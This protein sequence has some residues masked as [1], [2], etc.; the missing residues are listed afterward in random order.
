MKRDIKRLASDRYDLLVIGGGITGACVAAD[1]AMRGM[2]VAL[3]EKK[4]FGWAT[5]AAT[6]KLI[7][8]GLR[9]LKN[10]EFSLVRESLRERRIFEIIAPHLVYPLPFL[11][12]TYKAGNTR[13]L[14]Y[15][16]MGLYD[17]LSFDKANLS[18]PDRRIPHATIL[19][20]KDV[21]KHEP[22]VNT[23][24]LTGGA[25]YYDCQMF[26]PERLTLEFLLAATENGAELANY[27]GVT[28]LMRSGQ[29]IEGAFVR[30][31]ETGSEFEIRAKITVNVSGP[32]ADEISD[33]L[34][35]AKKKKIVRSQG[36]HLITRNIV[37]NH[38]VVL[39]TTKGRHFFLIPWRGYT[40]I[41]TTDTRYE[42]DPDDYGVTSNA[43]DEFLNEVNEVYPAGKLNMDDV[44]WTYGGLRPIVEKETEIKEVYSA[45]RKYEIYDHEKD[46]QISGFFTVIGGKYTTSRHLAQKLVDQV[47][48]KLGVG[49]RP[50]ATALTPL[51]GGGMGSW[52]EFITRLNNKWPN[53]EHKTIEHLAKVYGA[54][55]AI[56]F[57]LMEKSPEL[58]LKLDSHHLEPLAVVKMAVEEEMAV[59]LEDVIFR[60]TG[61]GTTGNLRIDTVEKCAKLMAASLGWNQD[62]VM[63]EIKM[64]S[65]LLTQK[66]IKS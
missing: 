58:A 23:V 10:L 5:S 24:G 33:F 20:K 55:T 15:P 11:I 49:F 44:C 31:K 4:D 43:V 2:K 45:S 46:D 6:S 42:G 17:I 63:R 25:I 57:D 22:L 56:L 61:L 66:G 41:G 64:V 59:H 21:L 37:Q 65:G 19:N 3:V 13:Y 39:R 7:H 34:R 29:K 1:A 26:S 52:N 16:A 14:I 12:P 40:L 36:V 18:D 48:I 27:A 38:A 62:D 53:L 47:V 35:T 28:G 60:R 30:D 9:Y 50:C 51:P 32:W 54:R 8:G